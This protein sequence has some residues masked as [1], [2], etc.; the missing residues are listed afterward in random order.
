M[1]FYLFFPE[2]RIWHFMEICLIRG[3]LKFLPSV[4]IVNLYLSM[5]KFNRQQ[6]DDIFLFFAENRIWHFMQNL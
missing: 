3:Q 5:G 6:I 1:I 4:L 2:N